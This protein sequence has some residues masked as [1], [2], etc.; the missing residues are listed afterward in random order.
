MRCLWA[1]LAAL[2]LLFG[3]VATGAEAPARLAGIAL[4]VFGG[5]MWWTLLRAARFN[6]LPQDGADNA[7]PP[8]AAE[9]PPITDNVR[10]LRP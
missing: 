8:P 9:P 3:A 6:P 4:T 5:A 1:Y 7:A 2:A 10:P